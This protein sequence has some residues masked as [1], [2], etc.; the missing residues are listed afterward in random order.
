[1]RSYGRFHT[2]HRSRVQTELCLPEN[3]NPFKYVGK[4]QLSQDYEVA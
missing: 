1:M 2:N 4:I 3:K